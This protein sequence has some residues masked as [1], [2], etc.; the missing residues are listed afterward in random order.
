ML[1]M[2]TVHDLQATLN[3]LVNE[4]KPR[5]RLRYLLT[6]G[7]A[8]LYILGLFAGMF[9]LATFPFGRFALLTTPAYAQDGIFQILG[10]G[11]NYVATLIFFAFLVSLCGAIFSSG[12]GRTAAETFAKLLAGGLVGFVSGSKV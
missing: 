1:E 7:D 12:P 3:R 9:H 10:Q 4:M 6:G 5:E 11:K 2:G 8:V